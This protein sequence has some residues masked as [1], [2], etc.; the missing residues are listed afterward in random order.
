MWKNLR[1]NKG[2]FFLGGGGDTTTT[3]K[4]S[5]AISVDIKVETIR[6]DVEY[7]KYSLSNFC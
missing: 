7:P 1:K 6:T 2:D 4:K 5:G 3:K